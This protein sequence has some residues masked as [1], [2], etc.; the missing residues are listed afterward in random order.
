MLDDNSEVDA[1]AA[2][3]N[4]FCLDYIQ[5]IRKNKKKKGWGKRND[6]GGGG[7]TR[8]FHTLHKRIQ[9]QTRTNR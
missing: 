8:E 4:D 7:I 2:L 3:L 6:D 1:G 5:W 9:A